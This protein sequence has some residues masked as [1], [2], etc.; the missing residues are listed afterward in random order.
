M[1]HN[2]A[3]LVRNILGLLLQSGS[4]SYCLVFSDLH[5]H[6]NLMLTNL[7]SLAGTRAEMPERR[8]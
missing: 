1:P 3:V 2:P 7:K 8:Q 6:G 4:F 5:G